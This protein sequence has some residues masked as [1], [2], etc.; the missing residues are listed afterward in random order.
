MISTATMIACVVTLFVSLV[1]PILCLVVYGIRC[2]KQGVWSAWLLGAAGFFVMQ[3]LIRSP[4]LGALA[5]NSGFVAFS[6]LHPWAFSFGLAV[7]AALFELAGRLAVALLMKKR[8]TCSRALAAGMGHGGIEAILIVGLT[9]INNLVY[10]VMIQTGGFDAMVSQVSASGADVSQLL[11]IRDSFL[12]L[13]SGVFLLAGYERLVTMI[14]QAA[15]SLMVCWGVFRK[16]MLPWALA[17][18]G[19]H[20]LM[21]SVAGIQNLVGKGLSQAAAYGIIYLILTAAAVGC[22]VLMVRICRSWRGM[23]RNLAVS[24]SE[25]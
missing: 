7:S 9:Y 16:R 19:V 6:Q 17:C 13:P 22:S 25:C 21:D 5:A 24:Q 23:E 1:L 8:L 10:M 14:C 4:I 11:A 15:M 2:R 20:T 18:L 12:N 3:I